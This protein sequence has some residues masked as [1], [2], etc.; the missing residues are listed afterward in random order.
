MLLKKHFTVV[1]NFPYAK[2]KSNEYSVL[3]QV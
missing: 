1:G 3:S 2:V